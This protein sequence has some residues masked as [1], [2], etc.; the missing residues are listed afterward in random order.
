ML[1]SL[2]WLKE[3]VD[4]NEDVKELENALTMIGQEVESIE[5]QGQHLE[6][7]VVGHV[8]EYS[9]H[10]DA[11]K[12]SLLKVNIGEEALL[13]IICGAPN[14]KLGD[15]VIVAKIGAVLPGNFKIKKSKIRGVESCGMLCSEAELGMGT[16]GDGIVILSENAPIG[17]SIRTHLEL[18]DIIFELEITPNRPDCLSHIGIAREVA[19]YYERKVRYPASDI[20]TLTGPSGIVV[21]I[22]DDKRCTRYSSRILKNVK[23]EESPKWLKRRLKAIGLRPINN[24]VDVTNYIMFEYNQPMHAFDHSKLE[25]SKIT[26]REAEKG[27]K[28]TTLD[29]E[30]RELN[31]SELVIA[32]EAKAIAIAGIMGGQNS[33]VD[34]N[35]TDI[36]LEV[37]YFTPENIRKTAKELGLSSDASYRFERGIDRDNTLVVLERASSLIQSI[38]NCEVVG[39]CIDVYTDPYVSREVSLDINKLNKFV[40]KEIELDTVGTILNSL[41]VQIKNRGENKISVTPPSYRNDITRSADLYEEIIRMYG[42]ENIED[43]MPIEEIKAG[44]VDEE[45]KTI[46]TSKKHLR[47]MGL[48]EVINYS[49]IPRG[50]LGKLKVEAE[51][52]DI[53]NPINEDMVTLRPTL[54]YGLLTNIKDNFNRNINDLKIFEVSRTFTKAETLADE[55]V[56]VGIALAGREERNLWEAKPEAY[57]FYDL[58]G[59]VES[60]LTD[61]GMTRYQLKRTENKSYHPGRA[62]DILIGRDYIGTFGEIHPDV[63][64]VMSISRERVYLAELE[65]AKIVKYGKTKIKYEKIVKYPAVNRDLAILMDRDKLVGDMLEDIKK[66]S[67]IIESVNLFDIYEGEKVEADKKSVAINIVLR[68]TT[69]TLEENEVAAAIDKILGL[70]KKKHQGEIRQ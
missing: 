36:L 59:Y 11:D 48:Q 20:R 69:G 39:E 15:K 41:N 49:F 22:K 1:I 40:G 60:Y 37:A 53:K 38:T 61:M 5:E 24:I 33:E 70:I 56:K 44:V 46:D 21:D 2:E 58:K 63:A 45:F 52:I 17:E 62:V 8:V 67:N 3:Y 57:D 66:S 28:I 29:G 65:L 9:Q 42:F 35:T 19:A 54:M 68:K 16:D 23:V 26:I 43:K 12:L 55:V 6:N 64:E 50:I 32:D 13:Q 34:E 4:I 51:T 27:E 18:D 7:V 30:E 25:G 14:H 31:N 47:D 10:P